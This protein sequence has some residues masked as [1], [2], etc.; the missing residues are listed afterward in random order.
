MGF[1]IAHVRKCVEFE[2]V[3]GGTAN[4]RYDYIIDDCPF[5]HKKHIHGGFNGVRASHCFPHS[6]G[7]YRLKLISLEGESK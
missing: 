3:E 2:E 7:A 1:P 5:C 6:L 4:P